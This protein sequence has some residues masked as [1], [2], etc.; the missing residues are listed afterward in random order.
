MMLPN[1]R[2]KGPENLET[3]DIKNRPYYTAKLHSDAWV[4]HAYDSIVMATVFGDEANTVKFFEPI[5]PSNNFLAPADSFDE[6]LHRIDGTRYITSMSKNHLYIMDHGCVHQTK[7]NDYGVGFRVSIDCAGYL[8]QS[9]LNSNEKYT[10][11][12][13]HVLL[14]LSKTHS[15]I[16]NDRLFSQD[17]NGVYV[18]KIQI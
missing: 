9:K 18:Q 3:A 7:S 11:F 10:Y 1:I 15:V 13:N 4:G 14:G 5:N 16:T 2:I 6:G 12:P 17:R 8:D